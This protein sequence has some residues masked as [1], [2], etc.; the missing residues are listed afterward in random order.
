MELVDKKKNTFER[1]QTDIFKVTADD[2]GKIL[3]IR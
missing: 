3:K 1:G 2:V